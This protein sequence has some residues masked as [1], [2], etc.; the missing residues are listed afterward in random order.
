MKHWMQVRRKND[1][2]VEVA[3]QEALCLWR[4]PVLLLCWG[5]W[6]L[7]EAAANGRSHETLCDVLLNGRLHALNDLVKIRWG[8]K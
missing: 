1:E 2:S 3:Y 7:A 4:R 6:C 8:E 5:H